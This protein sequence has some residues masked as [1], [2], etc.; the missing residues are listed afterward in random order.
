MIIKHVACSLLLASMVVLIG[1][2]PEETVETGPPDGWL[3]E[4]LRWALRAVGRI[5]GAVDVEGLLDV[6]FREFCIGK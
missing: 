2:L 6:I 4:D 5:T 1:C 3:A